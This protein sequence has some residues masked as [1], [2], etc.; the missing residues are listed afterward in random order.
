MNENDEFR[1]MTALVTGAS[2]GIGAET[3]YALSAR[4]AFALIHYNT[5][6]QGACQVLERIRTAG[7]EGEL[8]QADLSTSEGIHQFIRT[9]DQDGRTIDILVN[10]AGSLIKR[11][12]FLELTEELWAQVFMLNL[13]SAFLITQ[14]CLRAMVKRRKGIVINISSVAA[15]FG[16]GLGAIAYSSAKAAL[17]TM[18]KGLA[19]EFA[20]HGIRINAVSPGTVDTDYHRRFSTPQSLETV[21]KATPM[22]RLGTSAEVADVVA[23]LC[24]DRARFV[25]G[26]IIEVNGGF[27]MV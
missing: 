19:R 6:R 9:F 20:P 10:N 16:G 5:D 14:A 1:G 21:A 13:T 24:S 17:S 22:G 27:L 18:T 11:S 25:Q 23:F 4:G 2:K 3:A 7:G 26:Q 8:M 15:R 12:S